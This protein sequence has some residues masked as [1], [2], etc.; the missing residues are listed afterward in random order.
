M[1]AVAELAFAPADVSDGALMG[2][3]LR[4]QREAFDAL[5]RRH[6]GRLVAYCTA[7]TGDPALGEDLAHDTLVRALRYGSSFDTSKPLWPWLK[8]IA[9][10]VIV[11]HLQ[12]RSTDEIV[13]D[14][15]AG[16]PA[17]E[18]VD[19]DRTDGIELRDVLERAMNELCTRH[20]A[21]LELRYV[22]DR[23]REEAADILGLNRNGLDQ[24]VHRAISRLR[25]EYAKLADAK[26]ALALLPLPR[27]RGAFA[28]LRVWADDLTQFS[29]AG[30]SAQ[31]VAGALAATA[32]VAVG[33]GANPLASEAASQA[34]VA[35]VTSSSSTIPDVLPAA[36]ASEHAP[37]TS[38][39]SLS[40]EDPTVT[41][42]PPRSP[43]SAV[44][45]GTT[46]ETGDGIGLAA[47]GSESDDRARIEAR[48][49][50]RV[51]ERESGGVIWV[52]VDCR[53]SVGGPTC[54]GY[55]QVPPIDP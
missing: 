13:V 14:L 24:L 19:D 33:V 36:P 39:A 41:A 29:A 37:S 21:A 3:H 20:R 26:G 9:G 6:H 35:P 50:V 42:A 51:G 52:E 46:T 47:T 48:D 44:T 32:V 11:D 18:L 15:A 12:R 34:P 27:L 1:S 16:V 49:S 28:R 5:Y 54:E 25:K 43:R 45:V 53:S 8:A 2:A 23:S 30:I 10:N 38:T 4:G 17:P 55:E 7:R 40:V 31:A 22:E